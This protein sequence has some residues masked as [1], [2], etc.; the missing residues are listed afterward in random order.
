MLESEVQG[1]QPANGHSSGA[2]V[3]KATSVSVDNNLPQCDSYVSLLDM[4][5]EKYPQSDISVGKKKGRALLSDTG[6][7]S[8]GGCAR[9]SQIVHAEVHKSDLESSRSDSDFRE[10]VDSGVQFHQDVNKHDSKSHTN[11]VKE[12]DLLPISVTGEKIVPVGISTEE[13]QDV[14]LSTTIIGEFKQFICSFI[15]L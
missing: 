9:N 14:S 3:R 4:Y 15:F 13:N 11:E 2:I 12:G 5:K 1:Q 8:D 10:V 7:S 6:E